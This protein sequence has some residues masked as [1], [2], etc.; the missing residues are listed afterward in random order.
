MID[1][2]KSVF[3]MLREPAMNDVRSKFF[4]FFY[5]W[6]TVEKGGWLERSWRRCGG[7]DGCGEVC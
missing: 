1:G 3:W 4:F 6:D 7:D 2:D 5:V